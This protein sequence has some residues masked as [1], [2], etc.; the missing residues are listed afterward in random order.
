VWAFWGGPDSRLRSISDNLGNDYTLVRRETPPNG[1]TDAHVMWYA[2]ITTGGASTITITLSRDTGYRSMLVHEVSG[3]HATAPVDAS[4]FNFQATPT[5]A[6]DNITSGPATT[7][8]DGCYIF[9]VTA[10]ESTGARGINA[11]TG[12]TEILAAPGSGTAPNAGE[13]S[14]SSEQLVQT[15]AGSIAATFTL[16]GTS[17]PVGTMLMALKPA[18]TATEAA[19]AQP[20]SA[21]DTPAASE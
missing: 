20:A 10:A 18:V 17:A 15:T 13:G 1:A 8:V 14:I 5:T 19:I 16:T 6:I 21:A 7:T 3:R 2:N 12:F 11:G 4:S 9:G